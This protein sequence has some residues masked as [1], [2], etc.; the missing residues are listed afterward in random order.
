[1]SDK[2]TVEIGKSS[3]DI[4]L[5]QDIELA[6]SFQLPPVI[7]MDVQL[8][9]LWSYDKTR[10]LAKLLLADA[11]TQFSG[12]LSDES[13]EVEEPDEMTK[14]MLEYMPI[15]T[16]RSFGELDNDKIKEI[17]DKLNDVM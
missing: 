3:R 13:G 5:T 12:S 7:D 4:E 8:G 16:L 1:M 15:R 14:A 2:Y 17:L 9:E 10:K 6:G 11:S